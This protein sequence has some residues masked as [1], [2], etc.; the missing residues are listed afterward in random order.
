ME[1][2]LEQ[3]IAILERTPRTLQAMLASLAPAWTDATEGPETW[4][5]YVIVTFW[6]VDAL[7]L[8]V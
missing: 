3:G 2:D 6:T 4:S 7:T 8:A 1:F 5:P